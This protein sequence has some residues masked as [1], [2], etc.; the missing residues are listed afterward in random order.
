MLTNSITA[1]KGHGRDQGEK[2]EIKNLIANGVK[3]SSC[4]AENASQPWPSKINSLRHLATQVLFQSYL[5]L[6]LIVF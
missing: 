5:F 4:L 1:E 3:S 2:N 6:Y